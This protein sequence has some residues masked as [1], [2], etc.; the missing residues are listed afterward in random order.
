MNK[1][2]N[3][4]QGD[5]SWSENDG[6]TVQIETVPL[7]VFTNVLKTEHPELHR[8][9]KNAV[10]L[11]M[12]TEGLEPWIIRGGQHSVFSNSETDPCFIKL[13]FAKHKK[14]IVSLLMDAGY[15]M[16]HFNWNS[17]QQNNRYSR[18]QAIEEPS[19]DAIFAK[20]D[21]SQCVKNKLNLMY[22]ETTLGWRRR[23]L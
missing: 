21:A 9:W 11:K 18:K 14:E 16:V 19:W 6:K 4:V 2:H 12:D 1:G 10:W 8:S 17:I 15:D 3:H 23:A 22:P 13:E 7:D 20:R 5:Q